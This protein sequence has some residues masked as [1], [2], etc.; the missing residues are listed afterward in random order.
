MSRMRLVLSVV[1]LSVSPLLLA[2]SMTPKHNTRA[3][4][5]KYVN[6]AAK[7]VSKKGP[8]CAALASKDWMA[9]DY[10]VFVA[11]ADHKLLCHPNAK[12]VGTVDTDIVDANGKNVGE[13]F[14]KVAAKGGW[15]EYVW[16]RPGQTQPVA[17]STYVREVKG[18]DGKM[19]MVGAG[20]YE[21]K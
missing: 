3:E 19:Y 21:V 14:N 5:K 2:K 9:G 20:G 16:P 12:L 17:K 6:D 8:D 7:V 10:Y 1:L 13:G 11:D 15:V 18:P 4:I